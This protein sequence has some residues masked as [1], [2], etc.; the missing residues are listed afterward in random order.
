M[1]NI[2]GFVE[3][4][5][6]AIVVQRQY[7]NDGRGCVPVKLYLQIQALDWMPPTHSLSFAELGTED[8]RSPLGVTQTHGSPS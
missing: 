6:S 8:K 2:S 4:T 3:I 7:I 1:V 5:H